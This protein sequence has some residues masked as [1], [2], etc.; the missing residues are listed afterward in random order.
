MTIPRAEYDA[1]TER[2]KDLSDPKLRM[3]KQTRFKR[4]SL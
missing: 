3:S 1:L 2:P 4:L